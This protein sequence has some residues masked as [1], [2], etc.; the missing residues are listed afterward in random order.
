MDAPLDV[1][2]LKEFIEGDMPEQ[3]EQPAPL[4]ERYG[5]FAF[6]NRYNQLSSISQAFWAGLFADEHTILHEPA[7]KQFYTYR[8][9]SGL[10][11][12][13]TEASIRTAL[14]DRILRASREWD[15]PALAQFRASGDLSGVISHLKGITEEQGAFD[16][17]RAFIHVA[18]GIINLDDPD[19]NLEPF[20]SDKRSRNASPIKYVKGSKCRRFLEELLGPLEEADKELIQKMFGQMI[21]GRNLIQRFMI[22][23][24][25][26]DAGKTQLALII[27][28][29]IGQTNCAQM[30]TK[31]LEERF[32]L[33]RFLNRTLLLGVDVPANF[34]STPAA[35]VIKG[36]V[37][38][39]LMD[40]ERKTSNDVFQFLG[41]LNCLITSNS[42]Q[43]VRLEGD[44]A[45]W[46]RRMVI[47]RYTTPRAGKK[48]PDFY[49]VLM[50][51]EGPGILNWAL[52]GLRK[53][54]ADIAERGDIYI[55]KKHRDIVDSLMSE[56]DSLRLFAISELQSSP[57]YDLSTDEIVKAYLEYCRTKQWDMVPLSKI[58]K[59]L[60]DIMSDLFGVLKAHDIQRYGKK[61]RG[62]SRMRFRSQDDE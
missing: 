36:L 32:E 23:D 39:D 40:A 52:D 35:R 17:E 49:K 24:G 8:G 33:A 19:F 61:V 30:R 62:F 29:T 13:V 31:L 60:P 5:P 20:S 15:V 7:E 34:L 14:A 38:G 2:H 21:L 18:N 55:D 12:P 59:M 28:E 51:E 26:E 4:V 44:E 1:T 50:K 16:S 58:E 43:R 47:V 48:I 6:T 54:K 11:V 41:T 42:R 45:A 10:Y 3:P 25:E 27:K 9:D 22:L 46:R 57:G 37:G 56:S 53:L